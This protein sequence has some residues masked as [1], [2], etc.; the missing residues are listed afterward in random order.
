[1][2]LRLVWPRDTWERHVLVARV[3]GR[4]GTVLDVG[5][6]PGELAALLPDCRVTALNVDGPADIVSG[7]ERLP[8]GDDSFDVVTSLDV[9]E[10]LPPDRRRSHLEELVRVA[11]R[12]VL[13]CCPLG[14]DAHVA[15][16]RELSEWYVSVAGRPHRFLE[17]HLRCGLPTE[18][19]LQA[20]VRHL[21]FRFELAFHGD[22]RRT[23][24]TFRASVRKQ[25]LRYG[26][27][28]VR[29]A[30]TTLTSVPNE[31]TNRAFLTGAPADAS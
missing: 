19:E 13:V 27:E 15:A 2:A 21:P 17:E 25:L 11:R 30:D 4:P 16:E 12:Q 10:H 5:G 29:P 28:A 18:D 22:F 6:H 14:T 26:R 24:G 8:F 7:G 9:L 20:L 23:N 3:V 31:F 1:M